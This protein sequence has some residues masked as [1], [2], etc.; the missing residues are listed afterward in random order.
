MILIQDAHHREAMGLLH[1][2]ERSSLITEIHQLRHQLEQLKSIKRYSA[3]VRCFDVEDMLGL[4]FFQLSHPGAQP[5]MSLAGECGTKEQR[6]GS[7]AD[8]AAE[9]DRLL[10][11]DLKV[12]LSQTKLELETTLKA[13][14]KHLKELDTLRLDTGFVQRSI[15]ITIVVKNSI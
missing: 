5:V 3:I 11:E 14:H 7:G 13:Q 6:D 4:M 9:A 12:E 10:V 15:W 2:A 8:G 1:T